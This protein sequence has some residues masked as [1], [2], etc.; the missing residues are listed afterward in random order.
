MGCKNATFWH[1]GKPTM[2]LLSKYSIN[3]VKG[4]KARPISAFLEAFLAK[5]WGK[6]CPRAALSQTFDVRPLG[7]S[8]VAADG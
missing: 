5:L 3:I 6:C 2:R 4:G 7:V 8:K 1:S